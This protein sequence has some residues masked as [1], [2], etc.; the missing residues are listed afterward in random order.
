MVQR[1]TTEQFVAKAT[2]VHGGKFTYDKAVYETK[3]S[4]VVVTCPTHGDYTVTAT[5]HLL[6]FGCKKCCHD[7]KKGVRTRKDT[8][9]YLARKHAQLF[10]DMFFSGSVC[11]KCG[12]VT[13]YASNN[14]C[15]SCSAVDRKKSNQKNDGIRH[16]RLVNANIYANDE[17]IQQHIRDI[18]ACSR[19]MKADFQVDLYV[20]HVVPLKGKDVCGLHVPWNLRITTAKYNLSKSTEL[21]QCNTH[22]VEFGV[23]TVHESALP[24]N[25]RKTQHDH[26]QNYSN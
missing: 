26:L 23:V 8:P 19:K 18:Y 2:K 6:G 5:V 13:R 16:K 21:E 3:K 15:K 25:L 11:G 10:G 1:L 12:G 7:A 9:Q 4:K 17:A 14:A 24:W 22:I 20:D